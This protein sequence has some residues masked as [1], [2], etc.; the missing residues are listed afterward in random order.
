MS[1]N[2]AEIAQQ[3]LKAIQDWSSQVLGLAVVLAAIGT[4]TMALLELLK[5]VTFARPFFHRFM[6]ARCWV[7]GTGQPALDELLLLVAGGEAYAWS[8]YDQPADRLV[9]SL[10]AAAVIALNYP[11]SYP[12]AYEFLVSSDAKSP[13]GAS[14]STSSPSPGLSAASA[15]PEMWK[16]ASQVTQRPLPDDANKRAEA[17]ASFQQAN[18]ARIRLGNLV[19]HK[20][21]VLSSRLELFWS[22]SNQLAALIVGGMLTFYFLSLR[23]DTAPAIDGLVKVICAILGGLIAPFAKDIVSALSGLGSTKKL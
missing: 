21:D 17:L 13:E 18:E 23:V 2:A 5:A 20:I 7:G 12:N 9:A 16:Q 15:D 4:I 6:I 19:Q 14:N 3:L 8:W 1:Q 11:A 10:Q 22:R